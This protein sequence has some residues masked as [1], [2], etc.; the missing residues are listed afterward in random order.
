MSVNQYLPHWPKEIDQ[1][2]AEQFVASLP[3][4][5]V[6]AATPRITHGETQK[7]RGTTLWAKLLAVKDCLSGKV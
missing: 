1:W 3:Q 4:D 5:I 2:A 6:D 7:V